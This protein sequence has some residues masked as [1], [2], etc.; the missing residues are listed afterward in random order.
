L[1]LESVSFPVLAV[2]TPASKPIFP[3]FGYKLAMAML[4]KP[5]EGI[6][7]AGSGEEPVIALAVFVVRPASC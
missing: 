2:D 1:Y 7:E 5:P 3:V 6:N 4:P